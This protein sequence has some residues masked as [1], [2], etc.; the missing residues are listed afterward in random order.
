[1][2]FGPGTDL[3][4]ARCA[5]AAE[6][7]GY[8]ADQKRAKELLVKNA[9]DAQ[10]EAWWK[11]TDGRQANVEKALAS[12]PAAITNEPVYG[13]R[14]LAEILSNRPGTNKLSLTELLTLKQVVTDAEPESV[15]FELPIRYEAL[16]N[17]GELVLCIDVFGP[18]H[19]EGWAVGHCE[20]VPAAN[21]DCRLLWSTIYETPGKHALLAG[22]DLKN[23]QDEGLFGPA[24]PFVLTNLCQ[25]TPQSAFF[26]FERGARFYGRLAESSGT[27]KVEI[28]S[29]RRPTP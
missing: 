10:A 9:E 14:P 21:G 2:G 18:D 17:L 1:L 4:W 16:T 5:S 19:E 6:I 20:C 28:K 12:Q 8:E 22:L 11:I 27:W 15:A 25:F 24:I 13:G 23:G 7:D 29:A 26:D 3:V